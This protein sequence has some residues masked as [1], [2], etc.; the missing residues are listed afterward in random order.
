MPSVTETLCYSRQ[1]EGDPRLERREG[2][3]E[4]EPK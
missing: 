3:D 2:T 4:C 1:G